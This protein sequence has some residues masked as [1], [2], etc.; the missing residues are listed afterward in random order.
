MARRVANVLKTGGRLIRGKGQVYYQLYNVA[1]LSIAKLSHE[2]VDE[3]VRKNGLVYYAIPPSTTNQN[4]WEEYVL[5]NSDR[6]TYLESYLN[7]MIKEQ[8][9]PG[10]PDTDECEPRIPDTHQNDSN[11]ALTLTREEAW[12][13]LRVVENHNYLYREQSETFAAERALASRVAELLA[14][15][16]LG[17]DRPSAG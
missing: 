2:T 10:E 3:A 16:L 13:M 1:G 8:Q 7:T 15:A 6:H 17:Q 4:G 5:P 14:S 11:I 9:K 12:A